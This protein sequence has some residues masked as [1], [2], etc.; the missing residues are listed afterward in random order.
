VVE[1]DESVAAERSRRQPE[2]VALAVVCAVLTV[3][4]GLYPDPL[5]DLARDA[6]DAFE[7]LL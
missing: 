5:F 3:A 6:G 7:S 1:E 2:V 4:A